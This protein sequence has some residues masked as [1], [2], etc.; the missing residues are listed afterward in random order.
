MPFNPN[1]PQNG[2][3]IDAD[4]SRN[5]AE[6]S[7][8]FRFWLKWS[9]ATALGLGL[10]HV[11]IGIQLSVQWGFTL[12]HVFFGAGIGVAQWLLLR[13]MMP[14]AKWWIVAS[15]LSWT[16]TWPIV[17]YFNFDP[18][19]FFS[20]KGIMVPGILIGLA[21]LLVIRGRWF[22][23]LVLILAYGVGWYAAFYTAIIAASGAFREL[24]HNKFP[25]IP[26]ES[27][28][29]LLVWIAIGTGAGGVFGIIT[30]GPIVWILRQEKTNTTEPPTEL[31]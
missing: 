8:G 31:T 23:N 5:Q 4:A 28:Q 10:A 6:Q 11:S 30:G 18:M 1:K 26:A 20:V 3:A 21:A 17:G 15:L 29:Q 9:L 16:M 22:Q 12:L 25:P 13:R 19:G 2:E 14:R 24:E 27:F 7:I